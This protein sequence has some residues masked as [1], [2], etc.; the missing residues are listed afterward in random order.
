MSQSTDIEVRDKQEVDASSGEATWEGVFFTP[1][2]D[3]YASDERIVL[4]ADMPGVSSDRLDVDLRDGALTLTGRVEGGTEGFE[5]RREEYRV[6]G[7]SRRF[8]LSD[9]IDADRIEATLRDG[10]LTLVLP[11]AEKALPRKIQVSVG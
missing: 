7:Y 4:Q 10:V 6:G 3:I 8:T 11:K 5:L 2:V 1:D 9:D